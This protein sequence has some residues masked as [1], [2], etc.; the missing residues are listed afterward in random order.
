MHILSTLDDLRAYRR[1]LSGTLGFVPTMG[2]LHAGHLSLVDAAHEHAD[3]VLVSVFV[4]P[5]QFGPNEDF[6]RYPRPFEDDVALCAGRGVDAIF[7]PT[8]DVMYPPEAVDTLIDVPA[9][10]GVLEGELRPGHFAGVCRVVAKLL[11]LAMADIAVFGRKDY[12]Q[13]QV[14]RAMSADL[15]LPTRILGAPTL[16]EADG[17]AMSSRNRYL[18]ETERHHAVG[19]YKALQAAKALVEEEDETNPAA[20]EDAMREVITA[21]R[22][23]V[24]YAVLRHPRTLGPLDAV[25]P[26]LTHGVVALVAARLGGT[27]LIDNLTLGK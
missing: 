12:Q 22:M 8:P 1:G 23:E 4:N 16:R 6:A 21:H 11:I 9:L 20:V 5:T 10:T 3:H 13:L 2:A 24:D 27:R 19:L 15:F 17:L 14:I 18:N 25:S 26:A 7:S